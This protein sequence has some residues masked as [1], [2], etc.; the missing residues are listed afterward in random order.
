G[1]GLVGY[2]TDMF[3]NLAVTGLGGGTATGAITSGLSGKCLAAKGDATA[4]GT[5]VVITTCAS[6]QTWTVPRRYPA[7][8]RQVPRR[9][10]PG[11]RQRVP[12]RAV[13]L[14]RRRQPA[15]DRGSG[16]VPRRHRLRQVP[17]RPGIVHSGRYPAGDLH[18]QR[19]YQPDLAPAVLTRSSF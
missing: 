10:R 11:Y 8:R 19:G 9:H 18:L 16:Y 5:P 3:D 17:R 13:D 15:V 14:Q 12:R 6:G 1:F 7:V 4:N 2:R